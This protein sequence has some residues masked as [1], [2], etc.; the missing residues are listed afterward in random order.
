MGEDTERAVEGS[1][2]GDEKMWDRLGVT[3]GR[4]ARGS[5]RGTSRHGPDERARQVRFCRL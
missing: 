2:S 1:C 3:F 5:G 4:Q